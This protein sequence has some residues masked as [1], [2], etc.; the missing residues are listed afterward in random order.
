M[1]KCF[2]GIAGI[3]ANL[4]SKCSKQWEQN[5]IQELCEGS[6][7]IDLFHHVIH[8]WP[9]YNEDGYNYKNIFCAICNFEKSTQISRWNRVSSAPLSK[10]PIISEELFYQFDV[11]KRLHLCETREPTDGD[12]HGREGGR[13]GESSVSIIWN[14]DIFSRSSN[15]KRN[16]PDGMFF[17]PLLAN[18]RDMKCP[19]GFHQLS[20]S[21]ECTKEV[22]GSI[23]QDIQCTSLSSQLMFTF[24]SSSENL[25]EKVD[26]FLNLVDKYHQGEVFDR[27]HRNT[28]VSEYQL[29]TDFDLNLREWTVP[30]V[31]LEFYDTD[32]Y[33]MSRSLEA[34][35]MNDRA[36]CGVKSVQLMTYCDKTGVSSDACAGKWY[37][38][39]PN[40]VI[41]T[42]VTNLAEVYLV[43]DSFLVLPE[44][45][46]YYLNFNDD[47]DD[48]VELLMICGTETSRLIP[49]CVHVTLNQSEYEG[50]LDDDNE[51]MYILYGGKA[52][53]R[54]EFI[55]L[56]DGRVQLCL[57]NL[58]LA[59]FDYTGS[60][61]IVNTISSCVSMTA[62]SAT[63]ITYCKFQEL[64]NIY[65][66]SLMNL[67]VA[68]FI[69]QLLPIVSKFP[70]GQNMCV[71]IAAASHYAWI[72]S[73]TWMT[74]LSIDLADRFA[75]RPLQMRGRGSS[76]T[77]FIYLLSGWGIPFVV[78]LP[79]VVLHFCECT[80]F[81]YGGLGCW[82][83]DPLSN[84][85]A[86]GVPVACS[87]LLNAVFFA[88]T[89]SAII[90]AQGKSLKL[91]NKKKETFT[92][93]DVLVTVKV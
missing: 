32:I 85:V 18:C 52:F 4:I 70:A 64:R 17:D 74:V 15:D 40:D 60:L 21:S 3:S 11:G 46:F 63:F 89:I 69:A 28:K 67:I 5:T 42:E 35:P 79:C 43:N 24:P 47:K 39:T 8:R 83:A 20:E 30:F 55:L 27:V 58:R 2:Y 45:M 9:V 54:S 16:C 19:P 37:E 31:A 76:K 93:A 41:S 65:G 23:L 88:I 56:P 53:N 75:F 10:W 48:K 61:D 86:F 14:F 59:F 77:Y 81:S 82:I 78:L 7:S 84:I 72:S 6:Q 38:T 36:E 92:M 44:S 12:G 91:Q 22:N 34:I 68:L 33:H 90:L 51:T 29:P 1:Y 49:N 26:C 62:L 57:T 87:L 71:Y 66:K 50:F 13:E 80:T 73:F 25:H